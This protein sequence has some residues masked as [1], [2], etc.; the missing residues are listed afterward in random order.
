MIIKRG[1]QF[2]FRQFEKMASEFLEKKGIDLKRPGAMKRVSFDQAEK[3]HNEIEKKAKE[4]LRKH[5][6]KKS[7]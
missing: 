6:K 2:Y 1:E 4:W 5:R 7:S 3:W